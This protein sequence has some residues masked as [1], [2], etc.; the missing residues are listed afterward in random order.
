[1]LL[2]CFFYAIVSL[3]QNIESQ[4]I[5]GYES[6]TIRHG[7]N[8]FVMPAHVA[9]GEYTIRDVVGKLNGGDKVLYKDGFS[10]DWATILEDEYGVHHAYADDLT[11]IVDDQPLPVLGGKQILRV[12]RAS[13]TESTIS[14]SGSFDEESPAFNSE[15]AP[16]EEIKLDRDVVDSLVVTVTNKV[17]LPFKTVIS[18]QF[19]IVLK[20]GQRMRVKVDPRTSVIVDASSGLPVNIGSEE[21]AKF[22]LVKD[23]DTVP[24]NEKAEKKDITKVAANVA[25]KARGYNI[26]KALRD[27]VVGSLWDGND[28]KG[29]VIRW[30][31]VTLAVGCV[32]KTGDLIWTFIFLYSRKILSCGFDKFWLIG[33][34]LR[35][36]G[37]WVKGLIKR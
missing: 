1:M 35:R 3:A 16:L 7:D 24:D 9:F 17:T 13:G 15:A 34:W 10:H 28:V 25:N 6:T 27:G 30:L 32:A 12:H 18:K 29:S 4:N 26:Q 5:V 37:W 2:K 31:I 23:D 21:I 22:E 33:Y 36:L 20:N 14:L 8:S 19:D 11:T